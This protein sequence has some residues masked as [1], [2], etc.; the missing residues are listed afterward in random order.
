MDGIEVDHFVLGCV[1]G[2][3]NAADSARRMLV[4]FNGPA[5]FA[6]CAKDFVLQ[7]STNLFVL[8]NSED[9]R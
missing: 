9:A 3:N 8:P 2:M 6:P 4:P 7:Q 1:L 5:T